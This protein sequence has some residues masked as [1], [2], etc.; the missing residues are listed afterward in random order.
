MK[1]MIFFDIDGTIYSY[2]K[3]I[4]EDTAEAISQL[5]QAGHIPVICTGRTKAMIF[6]EMLELNTEALVAGAGTYLEVEGE[7]IYQYE[8]EPQEA[9]DVISYM[10]EYN[11]MPI[12]EGVHH[13]Y[14]PLADIREEYQSVFKVY[15]EK[16][17]DKIRDIDNC[18]R[19]QVSKISGR[20][21][22]NSRLDLLKEKYQHKFQFVI[23]D[24]VLVEMIPNGYSKA[25]GIK[26]LIDYYNKINSETISLD[27]TYA[28]GDSMNDYEMLKY[29]RYGVAMGNSSSAF[30]NQMKYVT[31]DYDKGG[32]Y[33]S[34]KRFG[35][36]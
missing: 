3:G 1:K 36:I 19:I 31:E 13:L 18:D 34:L 2:K 8:M 11:I 29:V 20:L 28:Y 4:P 5:K 26:K 16:I 30:K 14:Y 6:D 15:K 23:H 12:P 9:E 25:V 10:R 21:F 27:D 35:L 24:G 17:P 22:E 7:V 33:L 32:I